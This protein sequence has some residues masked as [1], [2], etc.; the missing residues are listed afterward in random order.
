[1]SDGKDQ[2]ALYEHEIR[3]RFAFIDGD[4]VVFYKAGDGDGSGYFD[5]GA[6]Y[7][8]RITK[9]DDAQPHDEKTDRTTVK[10]TKKNPSNIAALLCLNTDFQKWASEMYREEG[11]GVMEPTEATARQF[12]LSTCNIGSRSQLDTDPSALM[13]FQTRIELPYYRWLGQRG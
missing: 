12:I 13:D 11:R 4:R 8:L 6:T 5:S 2:E 3:L 7:L 1:M 10:R 9:V